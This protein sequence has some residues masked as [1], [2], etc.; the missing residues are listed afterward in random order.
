MDFRPV[1]EKLAER[2]IQDALSANYLSTNSLQLRKAQ[3]VVPNQRQRNGRDQTFVSLRKLEPG[4]AG[5]LNFRIMR[6]FAGFSLSKNGP[7]TK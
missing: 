3:N 2:G 6:A 4:G 7:V 5:F 1:T